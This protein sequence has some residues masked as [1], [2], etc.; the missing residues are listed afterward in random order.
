MT[1][2]GGAAS[3][4]SSV[5]CVPEPRA[6]PTPPPTLPPKTSAFAPTPRPTV[7]V[8][9][10]LNPLACTT[11]ANF[12]SWL[13]HFG[14]LTWP[15]VS[16]FAC[17]TKAK[18]L[19]NLCAQ[20]CDSGRETFGDPLLPPD[21]VCVARGCH[22][23]VYLLWPI[24]PFRRYWFSIRRVGV[25]HARTTGQ[26]DQNTNCDKLHFSA[27]RLLFANLASRFTPIRWCQL[28]G[29]ACDCAGHLLHSD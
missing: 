29:F 21:N 18:F 10:V 26:H 27:P 6:T 4:E 23:T 20:T 13:P 7:L 8:S 12:Q 9:I 24:K 3:L 17:G 22:D 2:T 1:L 25:R 11:E 28:N 14:Q 16:A 5:C 19:K 15:P